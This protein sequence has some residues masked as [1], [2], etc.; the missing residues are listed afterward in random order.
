MPVCKSRANL[1][2]NIDTASVGVNFD[3]HSTG[4]G[5]KNGSCDSIVHIWLKLISY[6]IDFFTFFMHG[7][8]Q[9]KIEN[10]F[11]S[12]THNCKWLDTVELCVE[13]WHIFGWTKNRNSRLNISFSSVR[14]LQKIVPNVPG[15][16]RIK[17]SIR[18][19]IFGKVSLGDFAFWSMQE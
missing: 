5:L 16:L 9:G 1:A 4:I 8:V 13:I 11:F 7:I 15:K 19:I 3:T 14:R 6:P 10:R 2:M 12:C 18:N 17:Y